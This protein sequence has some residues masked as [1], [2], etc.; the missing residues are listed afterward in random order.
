MHEH[1]LAPAIF[2][3]CMVR[4]TGR[5]ARCEAGRVFP[6]RPPSVLAVAQ[7]AKK[8]PPVAMAGLTGCGP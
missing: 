8:M 3:A 1:G 5:N 4:S 6:G 2:A 7:G